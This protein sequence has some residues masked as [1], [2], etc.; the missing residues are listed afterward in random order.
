[1]QLANEEMQVADATTSRILLAGDLTVMFKEFM[2]GDEHGFKVES[3]VVSRIAGKTTTRTDNRQR[4]CRIA[5]A[6][7]ASAHKRIIAI[8][9]V[10][11]V[12]TRDSICPIVGRAKAV[13]TGT[14]CMKIAQRKIS[15]LFTSTRF[16]TVSVAIII[17]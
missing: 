9:P 3:A 5:G 14:R 15:P 11:A 6:Y 10:I 1:M 16:I 13:P 17:S 2:Q 8:V 4:P 12:I 7:I